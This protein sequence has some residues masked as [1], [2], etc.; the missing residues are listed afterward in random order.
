MVP[1]RPFEEPF[2]LPSGGHIR[3]LAKRAGRLMISSAGSKLANGVFVDGDEDPV[4]YGH[5]HACR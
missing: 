2:G 3:G 4:G 5:M 1:F